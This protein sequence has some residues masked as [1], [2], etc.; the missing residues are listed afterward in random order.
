MK[1]KFNIN[2]DPMAC[3]K[4]ENE[5]AAN[6]LEG[7]LQEAG[8][9]RVSGSYVPFAHERLLIW[10]S[11]YYMFSN[12]NINAAYTREVSPSYMLEHYIRY[13]NRYGFLEMKDSI[14]PDNN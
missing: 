10:P 13:F 8:F 3:A 9:E 14:F 11:G 7:M 2:H 1:Q 6:H 4:P 12:K 5:A